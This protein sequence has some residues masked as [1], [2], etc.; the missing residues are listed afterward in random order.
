MDR[1]V[2][3]CSA[4]S[5]IANTTASA[6]T[7]SQLADTLLPR[8]AAYYAGFQACTDRVKDDW[9]RSIRCPRASI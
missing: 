6:A 3:G 8:I 7:A 9:P 4:A 5:V 1:T 2:A